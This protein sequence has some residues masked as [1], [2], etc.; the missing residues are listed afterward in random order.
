MA[1]VMLQGT[2]ADVG[3]TLLVAGLCR[4]LTNRG[5]VVHPF[6]PENMSNNSALTTDGG[7]IGRAQAL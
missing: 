2:G 5:F 1:A 7:E 6:K 4:A 3:K